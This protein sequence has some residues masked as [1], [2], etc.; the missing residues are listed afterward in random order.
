MSLKFGLGINFLENPPNLTGLHPQTNF[1]NYMD[2]KERR[3]ESK[4]IERMQQDNK[5]KP[6]KTQISSCQEALEAKKSN[7]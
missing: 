2:K 4:N 7:S 1:K 5:R 3:L 6:Y